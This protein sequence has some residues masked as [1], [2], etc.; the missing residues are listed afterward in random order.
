MIDDGERVFDKVGERRPYVFV[1]VCAAL[2]EINKPRDI[3][4]PERGIRAA[5]YP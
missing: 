2:K 3:D 5:A 1:L 4:F